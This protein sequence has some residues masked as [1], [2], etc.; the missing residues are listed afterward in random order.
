L[1]FEKILWDQGVRTRITIRITVNK[2][3]EY[4]IEIRYEI[5]TIL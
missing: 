2:K 5:L 3:I 4:Q 1:A